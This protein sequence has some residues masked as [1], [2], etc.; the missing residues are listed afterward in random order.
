MRF[1]TLS[2]TKDA[3]SLR[4]WL[5]AESCKLSKNVPKTLWLHLSQLMLTIHFI[6][7]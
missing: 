3:V 2:N 5:L 4:K 7:Q 1:Q 6:I